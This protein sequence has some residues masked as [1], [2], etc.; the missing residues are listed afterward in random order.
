ME[1]VALTSL[2]VTATMGTAAIPAG[3]VGVSSAVATS[4]ALNRNNRK[5]TY[6]KVKYDTKKK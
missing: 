1:G 6:Y 2:V 4:Q 3:G 5:G